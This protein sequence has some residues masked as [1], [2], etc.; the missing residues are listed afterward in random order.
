MPATCHPLP[1]EIGFLGYF[2]CWAKKITLL[3]TWQRSFQ[4]DCGS[5][6]H[7]GILLVREKFF[8]LFLEVPSDLGLPIFVD[9]KKLEMC[10]GVSV[11]VRKKVLGFLGN[12]ER[13]ETSLRILEVSKC[14]GRNVFRAS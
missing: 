7:G 9:F 6:P 11:C 13:L 14:K 3:Q 5:I 4:V 8:V 2:G 10:K 12:P 1:K